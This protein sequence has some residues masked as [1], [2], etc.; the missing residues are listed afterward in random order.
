MD[1]EIL[2]AHVHCG[3]QFD[4]PPQAI[5]NYLAQLGDSGIAGA[6]MMP[7]V[8]EVYD[9]HD[10]DFEDND[11]WRARRRAAHQYLLG[12]TG[13]E[14]EIIPF[15]FIW[16]DFAV[17]RLDPR[18]RGIKWHR[19]PDEPPYH[20]DDPRC[21]TA[22]DDIRRRN[23]PVLLE[24]SLE[25]TMWFLDEFAPDLHVIIPHLGELNGGY[26][27]LCERGVWE[28]QSVHSDTACA[29]P[30]WMIEHYLTHYGHERLMFGSDFPFANPA[31]DLAKVLGIEMPDE[32]RR[33]ILSG[34]L[35]RLLA[36]SNQVA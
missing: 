5:E 33:A 17:E 7:P 24:E 15:F 35:R 32:A 20:Y 3:R 9:R 13:G 1:V 34:N 36:G 28:R 26:R 8:M 2:D 22:L 27:A 21:G 19:H 14:F 31:E 11:F 18:H 25:N 23:M 6:V 4:D 30:A 12:L 16:N 29:P 10:P